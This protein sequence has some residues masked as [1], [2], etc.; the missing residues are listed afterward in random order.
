[1]LEIYQKL[2]IYLALLLL[3]S[4]CSLFIFWDHKGAN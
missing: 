2:G 4:H 3:A 1:M